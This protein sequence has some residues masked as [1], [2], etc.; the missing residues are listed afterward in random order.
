MLRSCLLLFLFVFFLGK[1]AHTQEKMLLKVK[2]GFRY[3]DK[4][5]EWLGTRIPTN[6][7]IRECLKNGWFI[8]F[9]DDYYYGCGIIDQNGRTILPPEYSYD[10]D[11]ESG[12][13]HGLNFIICRKTKEG[14]VLTGLVDTNGVQLLPFEYMRLEYCNGYWSYKKPDGELGIMAAN[15]K[16]VLQDFHQEFQLYDHLIVRSNRDTSYIYDYS[17]QKIIPDRFQEIIP[18]FGGR[19]FVFKQDDLYGVLNCRGEK[20]RKAD[21][22]IEPIFHPGGTALTKER[23]KGWN[24]IDTSGK[25]LI[26]PMHNGYLTY[27]NGYIQY[28]NSNLAF[29]CGNYWGIADRFG[30][31]LVP[32]AY[33][34]FALDSNAFQHGLYIFSQDNNLGIVNT[35][36]RVILEPLYD[37]IWV[38]TEGRIFVMKNKKYGLFN[39]DGENILPIENDLLSNFEYGYAKFQKNNKWGLLNRNGEVFLTPAYDGI[40]DFCKSAA[41]VRINYQYVLV[42]STGKI[43]TPFFENWLSL[44]PY[45]C[46]G[47]HIIYEQ[48]EFSLENDLQA[49]PFVIDSVG[50][51]IS[52]TSFHFISDIGHYFLVNK[53]GNYGDGYDPYYEGGLMDYKGKLILSPQKHSFIKM[54]FSNHAFIVST[55]TGHFYYSPQG[56]KTKLK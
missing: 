15:F 14:N 22:E 56:I 23:G 31:N 32:Y 9:H 5:G 40:L 48:E 30:N 26:Q 51:K 54:V 41:I 37:S 25:L 17:G 55:R 20:V 8:T 1:E 6:L 35:R 47:G 18:Y 34:G 19:C 28:S 46:R 52:I 42:D 38:D 24:L 11:L 7:D 53:T 43:L 45:N 12:C 33:S 36:A 50:N 13:L 29:L 27:P 44:K 16:V 21:L 2:G 39:K 10:M 4:D 3:V 49:L